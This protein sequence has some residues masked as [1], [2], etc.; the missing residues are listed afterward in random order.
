MGELCIRGSFL[1]MGYYD[2]PEKT[3]EVFVQNPLNTHYPETIYRTGDLV[4]INERGEIMYHGRKDF[5]IKHRGNRIE[6]GEIENAAAAVPGIE[7]CACIYDTEKERI[8]LFYQGKEVTTK[9]IRDT[10]K[11]KV[12]SYMLPNVMRE[13]EE[14]PKNQ[15]GK[16]DRKKLKILYAER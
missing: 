1:A 8:V 2:N 7:M 11:E 9:L 12:P 13:V 4:S 3:A 16:I 15:N 6:L 5:Q 10:M 14:M